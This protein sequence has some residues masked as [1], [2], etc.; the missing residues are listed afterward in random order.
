M[1]RHW[2]RLCREVVDAPSLE[3]FQVSLDG[4]LRNLSLLLLGCWEWTRSQ[5]HFQPRLFYETM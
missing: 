2:S 1:V 3:V 5:S 4:A